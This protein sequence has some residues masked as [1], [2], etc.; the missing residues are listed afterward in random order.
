M[1]R[2]PLLSVSD[3]NNSYR[4]ED[5]KLARQRT[6][7]RINEHYAERAESLSDLKAEQAAIIDLHI[8]IDLPSMSLVLMG[9][10]RYDGMCIST[11]LQYRVL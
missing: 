4:T 2:H 6:V 8:T 10:D 9:N 5:M 1:L 7:T 11:Y 3:W